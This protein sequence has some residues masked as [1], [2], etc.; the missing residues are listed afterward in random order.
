MGPPLLLLLAASSALPPLAHLSTL[1]VRRGLPRQAAPL[2]EPFGCAGVRSGALLAPS[3]GRVEGVGGSVAF[4]LLLMLRSLFC[5][6]S[7]FSSNSWILRITIEGLHLANCSGSDDAIDQYRIE[8]CQFK[9]SDMKI[10]KFG[11]QNHEA[12]CGPNFSVPLK[13]TVLYFLIRMLYLDTRGLA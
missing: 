7:V 8:Y 13:L 5:I 10:L 4:A 11:P 9:E 1:T 6:L 12:N 2:V 3:E